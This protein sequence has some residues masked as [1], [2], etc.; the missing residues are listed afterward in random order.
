MVKMTA[1]HDYTTQ[2]LRLVTPL[3]LYL[4]AFRR[5]VRRGFDVPHQEAIEELDLIF[6]QISHEAREDPRLEV[7]YE[8]ARP[9]L[10]VLAD[11]VLISRETGW[12][13]A[14]IHKRETL[15]EMKYFNTNVGGDEFFRAVEDLRAGD[16][17]LAAI[18]FIALA[19]GVR[20]TIHGD[21]SRLREAREKLYREL[22][23][24]LSGDGQKLTPE[25]YNVSQKPME[26]MSPAVTLGV[27]ISAGVGIMLVY[28]FGSWIAWHDVVSE[29][30]TVVQSFG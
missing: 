24:Y 11:E 3:F 12:S 18:M 19:L 28:L 16:E 15:L 25:A 29:I 17:E 8:K 9:S 10:V 30:R 4:V 27:M 13:F 2:L 21:E 20:G 6:R 26:M 23:E 22:T 1:K 7:L 5:K 14:D